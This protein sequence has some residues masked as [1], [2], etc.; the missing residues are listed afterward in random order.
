MRLRGTV[1]ALC[2]VL[3]VATPAAADEATPG[4]GD[5]PAFTQVEAPQV[6][7][8]RRFGQTLRAEPGRWRPAPATVRYQWLRD[9]R[10]ITGATGRRYQ[11]RPADVGHRLGVKVVLRHPERKTAIATA[12][13]GVVRHRVDVR[14]VV[15][16][17]VRVKGAVRTDVAT[18]RR[19]A[20]ETFDD[21]RGWRGRGVRFVPVRSGGGFTLWISAASRVPGFS[22]GCSAEWS[23]RVGR[24]VIIN[25]T[26]WKHASPAWNRAGRSL[27]SY[28]HMVVNHETGHWLGKG[29]ASCPRRGALAPVMMQQ[30]KGTQGCRF[31]PWPT[32]RELRR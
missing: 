19:Q 16:Y 1:L 15:R 23:C 18:F 8:V 28:R 6:T 20:Q 14:R 11:V 31:N 9:D 24:N 3:A 22:S 29:H 21:P 4:S 32:L 2:C 17:S 27:R 12:R 26:R 13:T 25:A 5:L 7:G 10:P 30:S